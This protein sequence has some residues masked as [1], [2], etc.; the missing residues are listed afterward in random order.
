MVAAASVLPRFV[1][2]PEGG[3]LLHHFIQLTSSSSRLRNGDGILLGV[4]GLELGEFTLDLF[5]FIGGICAPR[6]AIP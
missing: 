4:F 5:Q 6:C 2:W 3:Q 1:A